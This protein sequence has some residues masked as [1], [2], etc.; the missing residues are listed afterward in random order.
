MLFWERCP[1]CGAGINKEVETAVAWEKAKLNRRIVELKAELAERKWIS[2]KD[3]L[4]ED[5]A[6]AL[7]F[8]PNRGE[9]YLDNRIA[10]IDYDFLAP[11][12]ISDGEALEGVTHWMPLPAPPE[13]K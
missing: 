5:R 3:W 12:W 2:V 11:R 13:E 9:T 4:P 6:T 7:V 1:H 10:W 8:S